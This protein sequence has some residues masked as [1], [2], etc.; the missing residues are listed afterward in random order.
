V[1]DIIPAE[2][3]PDD[4]TFQWLICIRELVS[5]RNQL[6]ERPRPQ[7][8]NPKQHAPEPATGPLGIPPPPDT[9]QA[10]Q[11][12][13]N[14][15]LPPSATNPQREP[16]QSELPLERVMREAIQR[17]SD[18]EKKRQLERLKALSRMRMQDMKPKYANYLRRLVGDLLDPSLSD[19]ELQRLFDL[20]STEAAPDDQH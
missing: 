7:P 3:K 15:E 18:S 20:P 17:M 6:M 13:T 4:L 11:G 10:A 8:E 5:Q 1:H 9:E 16:T 2:V 19:E 14:P 12:S